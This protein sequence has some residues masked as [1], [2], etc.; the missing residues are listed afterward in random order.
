MCSE[1]I[2]EATDECQGQE[3][4]FC[5]G[6]CQRWFHRRCIGVN[7]EQFELLTDSTEPFYC[8]ACT[9][10]TQHKII[11]E[12]QD[13]VKAL[14]SEILQL[15]AVVAVLQKGQK[16]SLEESTP[17]SDSQAS[18]VLDV[19]NPT[20]EGKLPW[21]IVVRAKKG[22]KGKGKGPA[23]N[24]EYTPKGSSSHGSVS[25]KR[26]ENRNLPRV[27]VSGARKVWGTLKTT[28]ATAVSNALKS[29]TNIPSNSL[30]VKRKF[31]TTTRDTSKQIVHWWFVIRGEEKVLERL[32]NEWSS[33]SIQTAWKLEPLLEFQKPTANS[34]Q[35]S[36]SIATLDRSPSSPVN[37]LDNGTMRSAQNNS[38]DRSDC[39]IVSDTNDGAH[40]QVANNVT[41]DLSVIA[42]EG[43]STSQ[44]ENRNENFLVVTPNTLLNT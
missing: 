6:I 17:T 38:V 13:N 14:T 36:H 21:N 20:A 11:L 5:D 15:K 9:S 33:V 24:K 44:N 32:Q 2:K 37:Q 34:F 27:Q 18:E 41:A 39:T 22:G 16:P 23:G 26:S 43:H 4:L 42:P 19:N 7:R 10:Q 8:P 28:T 25:P 30:T 29:L 3:A 1:C 40:K 31:K 35:A 12:L